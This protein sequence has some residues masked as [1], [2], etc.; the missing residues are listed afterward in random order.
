ML[1]GLS[2][3]NSRLLRLSQIIGP[4][5]VIP[6]SRATWQRGVKDGRFP[7]PLKISQRVT[8]WRESDIATL[9]NGESI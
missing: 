4:D 7:R 6:V 8:V 2:T 9:I 5:G 1:T 3:H